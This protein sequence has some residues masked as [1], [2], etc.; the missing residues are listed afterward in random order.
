MAR[1]TGA[2]IDRLSLA[3]FLALA[4]RYVECKRFGGFM[5]WFG[6]LVTVLI[7]IGVS[8][9]IGKMLTGRPRS[10]EERDRRRDHM[11]ALK[12]SGALRHRKSNQ[13]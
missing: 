4:K 5:F 7:V 13:P 12:V 8:V 10:P 3:L 11:N 9:L 1:S 6:I 2:L